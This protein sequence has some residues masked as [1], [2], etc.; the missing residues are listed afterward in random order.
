MESENTK[1]E[2]P[3]TPTIA[4]APEVFT[5][6]KREIISV[7]VT[8]EEKR[9]ITKMAIKDCGISVSEF[10]RTKIF[11]EPKATQAAESQEEPLQDEERRAYEE[12]IDKLNSDKKQLVDENLKLKVEKTPIPTEQPKETP[13]IKTGLISEV[14]EEFKKAVDSL[15]QYREK[16]Y[17]GFSEE[18]KTENSDYLD[19]DKFLKL[20]LLRGLRRMFNNNV[21]NESTGLQYQDM[22]TL[23]NIA[24]IDFDEV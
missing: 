8:P 11:L 21:L 18:K 15:F 23:S 17:A 2:T 1:T 24:K 5:E 13:I 12:T 16:K 10:V 19:K 22:K 9:K 7:Q 20:V 3:Q 4:P 6:K 14:E